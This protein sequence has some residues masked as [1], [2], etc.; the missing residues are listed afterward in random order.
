MADDPEELEREIA[1][2]RAELALTIDELADRLNPKHAAQRG[3]DRVKSAAGALVRTGGSAEGEP[4]PAVRKAA[5]AVGVGVVVTVTAL[6]LW[7]RSRR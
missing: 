6:V 5:I 3:A 1:R 2:T 4:D 7:R